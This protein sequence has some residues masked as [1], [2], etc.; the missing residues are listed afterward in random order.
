[1]SQMVLPESFRG[2]VYHPPSIQ[3]QLEMQGAKV[4]KTI[5]KPQVKK[6]D[7]LLWAKLCPWHTPSNDFY[8]TWVNNL[9][10]IDLFSIVP[11]FPTDNLGV[12][13]VLSNRAMAQWPAGQHGQAFH[14]RAGQP[15]TPK[16]LQIQEQFLPQIQE[17]FLLDIQELWSF[18]M[19][20]CVIIQ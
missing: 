12:P 16:A 7:V 4:W 5:P 14:N 13:G 9:I 19:T 18:G 17:L 6:S 20:S 1:M 10:I 11:L 15:G 2:H 3:M 8:R